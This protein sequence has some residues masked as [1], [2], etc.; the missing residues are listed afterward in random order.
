MYKDLNPRPIMT[1]NK[2]DAIVLGLDNLVKAIKTDVDLLCT[3]NDGY[4]SLEGVI[5]AINSTQ[6]NQRI[7]LPLK[8][9][10]YE[11]SSK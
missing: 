5:S 2:L 3:G 7:H 6:R 10:T 1:P 4:F 9:N 8:A 11:I